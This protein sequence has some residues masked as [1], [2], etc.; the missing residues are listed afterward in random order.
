MALFTQAQFNISFQLLFSTEIKV[1]T[2]D[3]LVDIEMWCYNQELGNW[4]EKRQSIFICCLYNVVALSMLDEFSV[5][6]KYQQELITRRLQL[7]HTPVTAFSQT[8]LF[9]V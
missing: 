1:N 6:S 2:I 4:N 3:F 9:L 5:I 7:P 8:D